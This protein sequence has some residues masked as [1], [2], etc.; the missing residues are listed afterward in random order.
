MCVPHEISVEG[1]PASVL[2]SI[3]SAEAMSNQLVCLHRVKVSQQHL[4]NSWDYV[5][6]GGERADVAVGKYDVTAVTSL[7]R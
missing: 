5:Y 3:L 6:R 4:H 7:L 2:G 1:K